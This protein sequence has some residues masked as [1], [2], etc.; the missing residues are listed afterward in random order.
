MPLPHGPAAK[1][2]SA[3]IMKFEDAETETEARK[4]ADSAG[5]NQQDQ[6]MI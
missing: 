1:G 4:E 6:V 2:D 3:K 5:L